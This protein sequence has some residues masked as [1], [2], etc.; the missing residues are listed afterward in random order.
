MTS[1]VRSRVGGLLAVAVLLGGSLVLAAA[2]PVDAQGVESP[3]A[4]CEDHVATENVT[5]LGNIPVGDGVGARVVGDHLYVTTTVGLTIFDITDP[6][7]PVQ[8]GSMTVDV[9]FENEEVPTN[10]EVLGISAQTPSVTLETGFCP[11][12][13]L[14]GCLILFDVRDK[15][16][17]TQL[18]TVLE[19]GDH[20]SS[21]L[22][23]CTFMYGSEGSITDLRGIFDGVEPQKLE[24]NW[25][26][27]IIAEE[28]ADPATDCHHQNEIRPG[29]LLVACAPMYLLSVNAEDGGSPTAPVVLGSVERQDG[30]FA[31]ANSPVHGVEWPRGGSDRIMLSGTESNGR[32][33][34]ADDN[35]AVSTFLVSGDRQ[36]APEF[37][38]ADVFRLENGTIDD[39]NPVAG[40][41]QLG[42]STHWFKPHPTFRD[43]G[44][45]ALGAYEHGT[46]FLQITSE[47][48]IIEQ[49]H[50]L[51]LR[52]ATSAPHWAPDGRHVYAVDYERGLEILRW[53]G[54]LF[55]PVDVDRVGGDSPAATAVAVSAAAFDRADAVVL[56]RDDLYP[57]SLA[58]GP[59]AAS[60]DAPILLTAP[61]ALPP[62]TEAEIRR[63]GAG[64]AVL[65]GGEAAI[66]GAVADQLTAM[67][68]EVD[69]I[70]GPNRF[71]TA[72]LVAEALGGP[73]DT[74]FLAEGEHADPARGWPDAI[75]VAAYAAHR[76]DPVLL[77]SSRGRD[78]LP[79][80]TA[81]ALEQLDVTEVVVVGGDAAVS[82]ELVA[83]VE[84]DG[85]TTRRLAG[86]TRYET[87]QAVHAESVEAGMDPAT[88]WLATGTDW[89]D[90]LVTGPAVGA[91]GQTFALV[92]GQGGPDTKAAI[93][94]A[95]RDALQRVRLVGGDRSITPAV[96]AE[97][98]ALLE[99]EDAP[100]DEDAPG[101]AADVALALAALVGLPA[102]AAARRRSRP[103]TRPRT[104]D[105]TDQSV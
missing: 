64:R 97:I 8:T 41:H 93:I 46:R 92:D 100:D 23:D 3:L 76:G 47:G 98:R 27:H 48:E 30:T 87:S 22:L 83:T 7:N 44:M 90:A 38:L 96:D 35:G 61:D 65:L 57:D 69:R 9:Q 12:G 104:T 36:D 10:G 4:A 89:P 28:G 17:P 63:L 75:A 24:V 67:G 84:A 72:A 94:D 78:A 71:A 43:G 40:T 16:A 102:G 11:S 26:E 103:H 20:T 105:P 66:G 81:T 62:E 45:V 32:P 58:G 99:P 85:R 74:A 21:C 50:F 88:L 77:A 1:Q 13:V 51:P 18:A 49:G 19:A 34:C 2:S 37:A 29:I 54:P 101:G 25:I 56:G 31:P 53:D 39:G 33:A 68:L 80:E 55:V 86:A 6:A 73:A 5:C 82:D 42:C 79:A 15:A 60:L 95:H 59:L 70:G 52:G 91:L 14:Q